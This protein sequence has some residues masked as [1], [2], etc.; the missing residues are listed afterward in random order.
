MSKI[1]LYFKYFVTFN[2]DKIVLYSSRVFT[3]PFYT[4]YSKVGKHD[5]KAINAVRRAD[6]IRCRR[7][8]RPHC[9][10]TRLM[11]Q[12]TCM[13]HNFQ[14]IKME[15]A[16]PNGLQKCTNASPRPRIKPRIKQTT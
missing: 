10:W 12:I 3:D 8:S 6:K 9:R 7:L 2:N 11:L 5:T 13:L 4:T 16:V 14:P 15:I 1:F